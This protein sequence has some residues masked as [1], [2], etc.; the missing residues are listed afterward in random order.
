MNS[1][2]SRLLVLVDRKATT[3]APLLFGRNP[4]GGVKRQYSAFSRQYAEFNGS[5]RPKTPK[6]AAQSKSN[7]RLEGK[8][9]F[10]NGQEGPQT[11][12]GRATQA[13]RSNAGPLLGVLAGAS[14]IAYVGS[15]VLSHVGVKDDSIKDSAGVNITDSEGICFTH[16]FTSS[17]GHG[18]ANVEYQI[19]AKSAL[20]NSLNTTAMLPANGSFASQAFTT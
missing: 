16:E 2:T 17:T 6:F 18:G 14:A 9:R 3:E 15:S 13:K 5:A 7:T 19:H 12:V 4:I 11:P 20:P 1:F 10:G 8:R